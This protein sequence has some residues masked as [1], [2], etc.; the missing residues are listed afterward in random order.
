[1]YPQLY[2]LVTQRYSCRQYID[3]PL[4]HDLVAAV[5]DIGR[6]APSACN[7]QP[8]QFVVVDAEP[9]RSAVADCYGREWVR[10]APCFIIALGL[11]D[12]AW[13]R[14]SDG[15]DHTDVDVAIAVEHLCLAATA[16][17]LATCWIC[18]FDAERLAAALALPKG[19]EPVAI[20]PLGYPDPAAT[21]PQKNR[22][23]FD[24]V[25]KWGAY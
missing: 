1:M 11:H 24:Q 7:R 14:P 6:L 16:M 15:K 9:L 22:K 20:L 17:G 5:L 8:W 18:N 13:H 12:Q 25:V 2:N 10:T 21:A 3:K 23:P 19:V 4:D